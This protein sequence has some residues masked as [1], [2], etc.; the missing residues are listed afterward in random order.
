MKVE[1]YAAEIAP[2]CLLLATGRRNE[3][4]FEASALRG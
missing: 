1:I 3:G 4:W 2:R